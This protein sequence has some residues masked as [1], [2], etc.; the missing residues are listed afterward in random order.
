MRLAKKT[1]ISNH[2]IRIKQSFKEKGTNSLWAKLQF[3][4][5]VNVTFEETQRGY[6]SSEDTCV[7]ATWRHVQNPGHYSP[8]LPHIYK[9]LA[10]LIK[11]IFF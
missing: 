10:H 7:P 2:A 11:V 8:S 9:T 4:V 6:R 1:N 3:F 5:F